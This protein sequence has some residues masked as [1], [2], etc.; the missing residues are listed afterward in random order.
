VTCPIGT[1]CA[2]HN[3][4]RMPSM[5]EE[6]VRKRRWRSRQDPDRLRALNRRHQ[7]AK[8]ERDSRLGG[9]G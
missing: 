6:A 1:K 5:T 7:R 4:G 9:P 2:P 8:R 3:Y